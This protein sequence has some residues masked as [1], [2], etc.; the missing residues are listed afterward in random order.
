MS[1]RRGEKEKEEEGGSDGD[2]GECVASISLSWIIH[3]QRLNCAAPGPAAV[4]LLFQ[5]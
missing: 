2:G 3:S 4:G 1:E 5:A